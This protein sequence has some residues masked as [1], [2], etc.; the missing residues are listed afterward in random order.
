MSLFHSDIAFVQD[1]ESKWSN[2]WIV[3]FIAGD[4]L[5]VW[6][7][8]PSGYFED[9][10]GAISQK[11]YPGS[12]TPTQS[13]LL[14]PN[15]KYQIS[16]PSLSRWH[17][18]GQMLAT[19][20]CDKFS[21]FSDQISNTNSCPSITSA[22]IWLRLKQMWQCG[23]FQPERFSFSSRLNMKHYLNLGDNSQDK[24]G[25]HWIWNIVPL[26]L[27]KLYVTDII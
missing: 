8:G 10:T 24:Y 6:C 21:L 16:T 20:K 12:L 7:S 18:I 14:L 19:Q 1:Q 3:A 25:L 23:Q 27:L 2:S 11:L 22:Q 4:K 17:M 26:L 13:L 15:S 5:H 9:N